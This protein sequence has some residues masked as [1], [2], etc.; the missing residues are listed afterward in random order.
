MARLIERTVQ[1]VAQ[2][3]LQEKYDWKSKRKIFSEI[4]VRTKKEH[5]GK[6]ADGFLAFKHRFWGT[7][8]V[9]MEAKSFKT[10]QAIKP[11]YDKRLHIINSLKAGFVFTLIIGLIFP[12]FELNTLEA[13]TTL[14][15]VITLGYAGL[16]RKSFRHQRLD[17]IDQLY[18][19]PANE[20]WLA[21]S[22]DSVNDL[23]NKEV[24]QL[25]SICR[26]RGVGLL[27]VKK[28]KEIATLAKARKQWRMRGD[29]LHYYS[30]EDKIR[31]YIS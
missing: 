9:S 2:K 4:E 29:Y 24:Q 17:V 8:V 30:N 27:I 11:Y 26:N 20:Q 6:R 16:S 13:F 10:L 19:Y 31:K 25:K 12:Y 3:H 23:Q 15:L 5:G 18:Q 14:F 7:Y 21:L 28:K 1:T 22:F